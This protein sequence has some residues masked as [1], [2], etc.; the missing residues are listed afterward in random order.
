[1]IMGMDVATLTARLAKAEETKARLGRTVAL[2]EARLAKLTGVCAC[3]A[4]TERVGPWRCT[5]KGCDVGDLLDR[6][7]RAVIEAYVGPVRRRAEEA[8]ARV[9]LAEAMGAGGTP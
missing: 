6:E 9:A 5:R 3:G 4:E 1:M 8:E 2:L 7:A